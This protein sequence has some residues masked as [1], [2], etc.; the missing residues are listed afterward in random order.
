[1]FRRNDNNFCIS[2]PLLP[3]RRRLFC[4]RTHPVKTFKLLLQLILQRVRP[5]R[6][7]CEKGGVVSTALSGVCAVTSSASYLRICARQS[8]SRPAAA[9][10]L[11]VSKP[12]QSA[13][14]PS[15]ANP[16]TP[17]HILPP[18]AHHTRV[19]TTPGLQEPGP[20]NYLHL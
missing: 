18:T 3:P 7:W 17:S 14:C 9:R 11:G 8:F 1:M 12:V 20:T 19:P 13:G 10:L 4:S 16:L 5:R 15:P 6:L 2:C